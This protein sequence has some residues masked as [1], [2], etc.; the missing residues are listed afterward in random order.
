MLNDAQKHQY[1]DQHHW[2]SEQPEDERIEHRISPYLTCTSIEVARNRGL[3][4]QTFLA[5]PIYMAQ[6]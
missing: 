1:N 5:S 2:H 4:Q 6:C 3:P